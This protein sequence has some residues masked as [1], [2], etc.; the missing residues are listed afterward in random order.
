MPVHICLV[1]C[2]CA[3]DLILAKAGVELVGAE[4]FAAEVFLLILLKTVLFYLSQM[5]TFTHRV[6]NLFLRVIDLSYFWFSI[7]AS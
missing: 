7:F 2:Y 1:C 4:L 5:F 3:T 6:S